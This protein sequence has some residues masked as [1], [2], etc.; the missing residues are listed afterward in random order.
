MPDEA[1]IAT[2]RRTAETP[3]VRPSERVAARRKLAEMGLTLHRSRR[4]EQAAL[5][6]TVCPRILMARNAH[7]ETIAERVRSSSRH[8]S[9]V[10]GFPISA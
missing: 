2:L 6:P 3:L 8:R 1:E 4:N 5:G 10:M 7:R 9:F